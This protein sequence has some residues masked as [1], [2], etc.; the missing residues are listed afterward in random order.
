M[1]SIARGPTDQGR[2]NRVS[3]KEVIPP[4]RS[5]DGDPNVHPPQGLRCLVVVNAMQSIARVTDTSVE[6]L[7]R[8]HEVPRRW[9]ANHDEL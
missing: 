1:Q 2:F 7:W 5:G 4:P 6:T 3:E 8:E 9:V